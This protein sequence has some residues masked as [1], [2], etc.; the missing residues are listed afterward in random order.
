MIFWEMTMNKAGHC[1]GCYKKL[2]PEIG[3]LNPK[4]GEFKTYCKSCI[5]VQRQ[6]L[7]D[8]YY[9]K[10]GYKHRKEKKQK[11]IRINKKKVSDLELDTI[12]DRAIKNMEASFKNVRQTYYS[13]CSWNIG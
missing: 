11:E 2:D 6:R 1:K 13:S 8:Y 3:E 10:G 5:G 4:T 12:S 9:K 7:L